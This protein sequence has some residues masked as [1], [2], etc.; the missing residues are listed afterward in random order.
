MDNACAMQGGVEL[1]QEFASPIDGDTY[2]FNGASQDAR[3]AGIQR[4]G[5][6]VPVHGTI[7]PFGGFAG[8]VPAVPAVGM[9]C[10]LVFKKGRMEPDMLLP[11]F[12][13]LFTCRSLGG[14]WCCH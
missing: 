5:T 2:Q 6:L 14:G 13:S 11:I 10:G 4:T 7:V 12:F 1:P 8:A 3:F 9:T